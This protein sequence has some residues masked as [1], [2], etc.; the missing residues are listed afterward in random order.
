[1]A[2]YSKILLIQVQSRVNET[3]TS[4]SYIIISM[5]DEILKCF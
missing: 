5:D 1:M 4:K 2:I 3:A